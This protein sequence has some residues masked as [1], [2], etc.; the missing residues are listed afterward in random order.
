MVRAPQTEPIWLTDC[1]KTAFH[2][3]LLIDL[4]RLHNSDSTSK[5]RTQK[6]S[7]ACLPDSLFNFPA[8]FFM[9]LQKQNAYHTETS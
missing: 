9:N 1:I 2:R 8:F 7:V 4:Q 5:T 6:R 3:V